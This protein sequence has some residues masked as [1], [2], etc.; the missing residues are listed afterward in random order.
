MEFVSWCRIENKSALAQ[1]MAWYWSG[2]KPLFEPMVTYLTDAL[3][4]HTTFY[5]HDDIRAHMKCHIL[6]QIII[7]HAVLKNIFLNALNYDDTSSAWR[8]LSQDGLCV[9]TVFG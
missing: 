3:I 8:A 2:D 7:L 5:I 9:H 6:F 1:I 4:R